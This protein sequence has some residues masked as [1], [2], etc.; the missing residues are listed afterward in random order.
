MTVEVALLISIVSVAFS[1][2]F[3]LKS[4]K[5]T[6]TKDIEERTRERTE[7][8][9]KLDMIASGTQEIKEQISSLMRD[10]QR[11]GDRLTQVEGEV[12][13]TNDYLEKLH[14]RITSLEERVSRVERDDD[15]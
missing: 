10:V 15:E 13:H 12:Q 5:M 8:N 4:N 6:D 2:F 1:I 11:H 9:C 7:L 3:G 14:N